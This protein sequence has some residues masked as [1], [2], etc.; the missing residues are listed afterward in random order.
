MRLQGLVGGQIKTALKGGRRLGPNREIHDALPCLT[1]VAD[2]PS[3]AQPPPFVLASGGIQDLLHLTVRGA[4]GRNRERRKRCNRRGH[5]RADLRPTNWRNV[6]SAIADG[7]Y[8][9]INTA[10]D[11]SRLCR[12]AQA[13]CLQNDESDEENAGGNLRH[14]GGG[15]WSVRCPAVSDFS[16]AIHEAQ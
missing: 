8:G 6:E 3:I 10:A 14:S 4:D 15:L 7:L 13:A 1:A 5:D 12:S 11:A 2:L 16:K 9:P